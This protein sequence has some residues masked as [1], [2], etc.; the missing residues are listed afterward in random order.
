MFDLTLVG[1]G[2]GNPD[3]LTLAAVH[4]LNAADLILIPRKGASKADLADLRR[5]ICANVVTNPTTQIVE[6]DLPMRDAGNPDY[7]ARVDDWHDEIAKCWISAIASALGPSRSVALLVWGD[8]SLYDSTLR[9]AA[10]LD[11][12][13]RVTVIPGITSMQALCAA[14]AIPMNDIAEP[15]LVTTGRRLRDGGWPEGVDT[16]V[17]MLD[18]DCAF[19]GLDPAGVS[20]WWA[21]YVGMAE[22]ILFSGPLV[23]VGPQIMAARA[24]ARA[25]H[26]WIMDIYLLRRK[27]R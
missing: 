2:T 21:G 27:L 23:T 6:F 9:I 13:P 3:H 11:P 24:A 1:I 22:E 5:A 26:G 14:H 10:R 4:A 16:L 12:A 17:V 15:V 25:A 19:Q 8:P 18:G 7:L 20:I